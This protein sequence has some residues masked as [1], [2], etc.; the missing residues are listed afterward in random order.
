LFKIIATLAE[1]ALKACCAVPALRVWADQICIS[2]ADVDERNSQIKLMKKIYPLAHTVL[3]YISDEGQYNGAGI[4]FAA[5]C[6]RRWLKAHEAGTLVEKKTSWR[7]IMPKSVAYATHLPLQH[8]HLKP[9]R[10]LWELQQ[11]K[12]VYKVVRYSAIQNV[13]L[14][15]PD[16]IDRPFYERRWIVQEVILMSNLRE[17]CGDLWLEKFGPFGPTLSARFP[18]NTIGQR[19]QRIEALESYY[20]LV[21]LW[22]CGAFFTDASITRHQKLRTECIQPWGY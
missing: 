10:A 6:F 3:A 13:A 4:A 18:Q 19:M 22:I 7:S 2:R 11:T 20:M 16:L 17:L 9:L 1:K 5:D 14:R 21:K 12:V 8:L 15:L